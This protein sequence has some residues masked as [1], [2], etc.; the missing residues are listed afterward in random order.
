MVRHFDYA[1]LD[2]ARDF[3]VQAGLAMTKKRQNE[4]WAVEARNNTKGV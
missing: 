1:P 2:D 3:A 4:L